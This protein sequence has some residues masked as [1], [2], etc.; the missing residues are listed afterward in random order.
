MSLQERSTSSLAKVLGRYHHIEFVKGE[1]NELIDSNGKRYIDMSSGLAVCSTG[2]CHPKVS[3]AIATQAHTLIHPCIGNGHY[4]PPVQLA[5]TINAL[6]SDKTDYSAFFSQS[7]SDANEAAIKL[8]RY[9]TKRPNIV[10]FKGGFHGRT[11]GALSLTTSKMK[12]REGY[13][14]LLPNIDFFDYPYTYRCPWGESSPEASTE[15]AIKALES[16]PLFNDNVAAVIIEPALGEAGYVPAPKAFLEALRKRCDEFGIILI[17]DEVQTG[18]ARTGKWFGFQHANVEPDIIT[19]AKGI[20]SGMPL[21]ACFAKTE[22]MDKWPP[23]AH[24]GTFGANPVS[25]AAANATIDVL[26]EHIND[27]APLSKEAFALLKN[28]LKDHQHVGDIRGYG[29]FIGIEWV[30]DKTTKE[31]YPEIIGKLLNASREAGI[32]IISCGLHDNVIRL[33]PPITMDK[34]TLLST[35]KRLC[36]IFNDHD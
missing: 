31:P 15:A 6:L 33:I 28:E 5:E 14:P 2:H 8:A 35:L 24:G 16:S 13:E 30:K 19:L 25:C 26:K 4:E 9:V 36:T 11:L 23:G 32:L 3:E 18:F 27:V 17:F 1:G 29:Y 21:G 7:G 12:Y 10:A 20:A 22:I 34:D